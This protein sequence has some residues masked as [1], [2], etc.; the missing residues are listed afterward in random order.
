MSLQAEHSACGVGLVA[1]RDG[2][3]NHKTLQD[4][5]QALQNL[6][7]RGAC[8]ADGRSGDGAGVLTDI[9][10]ELLDIEPDTTAL[11][12]VFITDD[13]WVSQ[14]ALEVF[15]STFGFFGL[16]VL[17]LR[18]VPTDP[19]VLGAQARECM[20]RILHAVLRRPDHC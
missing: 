14:R 2:E 9:P 15:K 8:A 17:A 16:D 18:E 19:T 5:L 11:A 10:Y 6:E 7:H 1:R 3:R 13:A 4:A 12:T 20:P